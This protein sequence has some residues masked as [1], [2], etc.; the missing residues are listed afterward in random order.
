[1][2]IDIWSD[3]GCP[4][5]YLGTTQLNQALES[6]AHKDRVKVIH[7]SFQLDPGAPLETELSLNQM[8][9]NKKGFSVAVAD[10][11]NQRVA[12]MFQAA[13][14]AMNYQSAVPVNTLHAH[15][16]AHF[17]A[18]QGKQEEMLARLFK[19]YFTNGLNTADVETL[20]ALAGEVDLDRDQTRAVLESDQYSANVQADID[21]AAA[22]GIQGVPFFIF[23]D[24]YAISG[25][26]G[27]ETFAQ[28]LE[29]IWQ[30]V[31]SPDVVG[32]QA[33]Q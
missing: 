5:C 19:A 12:A 28:A 32:E 31:H 23:E 15:R 7:H 11:M 3:I 17:A 2:K 25:A 9:A 33:I 6:F 26:Q 13:G 16:L 14:L 22:F 27:T 20:V 8:L 24:K 29:Q 30:K 21:Q 1:M 10:G 18:E 4:F